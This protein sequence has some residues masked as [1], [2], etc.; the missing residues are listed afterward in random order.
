MKWRKNSSKK[1]VGR[2]D[3]FHTISNLLLQ[4]LSA[5][6]DNFQSVCEQYLYWF[7]PEVSM[8]LYIVRMHHYLFFMRSIISVAKFRETYIIDFF[9]LNHRITYCSHHAQSNWYPV[10]FECQTIRSFVLI[11]V[12]LSVSL[13]FLTWRNCCKHILWRTLLSCTRDSWNWIRCSL[14]GLSDVSAQTPC[15]GH[16]QIK[17]YISLRLNIRIKNNMH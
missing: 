3:S 12:L 13:Y 7:A 15:R 1:I 14:S 8:A 11:C 10:H 16:S 2:I 6:K 5:N 4:I 17:K 9:F